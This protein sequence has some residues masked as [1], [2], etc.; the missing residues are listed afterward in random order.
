MTVDLH[1]LTVRNQELNRL[2]DN[3]GDLRCGCDNVAWR[4]RDANRRR[5]YVCEY[6]QGYDDGVEAALRSVERQP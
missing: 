4:G 5:A 1:L 3:V 6:H 2:C